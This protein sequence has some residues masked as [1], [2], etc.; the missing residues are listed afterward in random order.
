MTDVM[1]TKK[2]K[3]L[4]PTLVGGRAAVVQVWVAGTNTCRLCSY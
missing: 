4:Y 3:W 1:T 2:P